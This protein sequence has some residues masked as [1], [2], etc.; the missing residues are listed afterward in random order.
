MKMAVYRHFNPCH[1]NPRKVREFKDSTKLQQQAGNL[2][3]KVIVTNY[4]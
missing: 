2:K 3:K 1:V 4:F